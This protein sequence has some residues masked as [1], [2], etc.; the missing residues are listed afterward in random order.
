MPFEKVKG[1]KTDPNG[2]GRLWA[3]VVTLSTGTA[4]INYAEDLPGVS[5]ELPGEPVILATV[6]GEDDYVYVSATGRSQAT[7]NGSGDTGSYD[8]NVRIHEQGGK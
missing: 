8:V 4:N 7:V 6:K 5:N 1:G 3:G 2:D